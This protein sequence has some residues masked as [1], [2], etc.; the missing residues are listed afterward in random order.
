M[1]FKAKKLNIDLEL[2]F[3]EYIPEKDGGILK[4]EKTDAESIN[5]WLELAIEEGDR[6]TKLN[7]ERIKD[8]TVSLVDISN[9][10]RKS[11]L[12]QIDYFYNKGNEYY[13]KIP[14]MIL[15]D[16]LQYINSQISPA[17]KKLTN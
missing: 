3:T 5:K 13:K 2:D 9:A 12:K 16:A 4:T 1:A 17:K 11:V 14:M 10:S 15:N 6:L 8:N 7:D